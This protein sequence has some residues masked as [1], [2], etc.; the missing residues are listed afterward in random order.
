MLSTIVDQE[1]AAV[2]VIQH[3]PPLAAGSAANLIIIRRLAAAGVQAQLPVKE[4]P[5][6]V[7]DFTRFFSSLLYN[8]LMVAKSCCSACRRMSAGDLKCQWSLKLPL[9]S[10]KQWSLS[11]CCS[12]TVNVTIFAE[13]VN[14]LSA[15]YQLFHSSRR[16]CFSSP[17][18]VKSSS[19]VTELWVIHFGHSGHNA[20]VQRRCHEKEMKPA[21]PPLLQPNPQKNEHNRLAKTDQPLIRFG[22]RQEA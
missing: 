21:V 7:T 12:S 16:S 22:W 20:H 6:G 9:D 4:A 13:C 5:L 19:A 18:K 1:S 11:S 3:L 15:L 10:S 14:L 8:G 2:N 17:E